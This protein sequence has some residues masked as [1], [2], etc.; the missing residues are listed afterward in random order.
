[1]H[2]TSNILKLSTP[3]NNF[4]NFNVDI[5]T[6]RRSMTA[7]CDMSSR[8]FKPRIA[9]N[10][11]LASFTLEFDFDTAVESLPSKVKY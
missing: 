2:E 5:L 3:V 9:E 6:I 8:S 1:M 7:S 10:E 11:R 4:P